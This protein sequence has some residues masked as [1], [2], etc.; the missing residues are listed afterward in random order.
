MERDDD[1]RALPEEQRDANSRR[2]A[3]WNLLMVLLAVASLGPILW[4]ELEDIN[5]PDPRFQVLAAVDLVFV[6]LFFGDFAFGLARAEDRWA[7]W[8][9]HWYELPGLIPLYC[10]AFAILRVAQVLRLAR[11]LR[12]LRA[13]TALRRLRSLA[14]VDV[15]INRNKLGHT[16]VIAASVVL[17]LAWVV[18][19]LEHDTNPALTDFGD[20]LWWAIV[21]TTTVGYGDITPQTG[22]AR[23]VATALMLMGIGLIGVVASSISAAIIAVG[24]SAPE[25]TLAPERG[26]SLAS[27]LE[28]LAALRERGHLTEEE[29]TAAKRKLLG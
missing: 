9:R 10:E 19:L 29:F 6:L 28:R 2:K 3:A 5:W 27:E 16:L 11:V 12:L 17:S 7:W 1:L 26:P 20:A 25:D 13:I 22:L 18:W 15:L 8:K 21:T 14:F 4:V 24:G 23:L